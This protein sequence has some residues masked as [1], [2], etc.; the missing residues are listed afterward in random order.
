MAKAS[1]SPSIPGPIS[2]VDRDWQAE[3]DYRSLCRA[4]EIAADSKRLKKA[5]DY[6]EQH[7]EDTQ[8]FFEKVTKTA[9]KY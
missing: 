5:M 3:D 2:M 4:A 6:G 8:S 7:M 9:S 1:K